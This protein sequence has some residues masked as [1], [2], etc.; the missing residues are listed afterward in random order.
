V[1]PSLGLR[2]LL[3][4]G[5]VTAALP[6]CSEA[7]FPWAGARAT[8]MGGAQVAAVDDATAAWS[9]PAAL[10]RLTGW[11]V[12]LLGSGLASNRNRLLGTVE[13]LS[14]LPFDAIARGDRPDLV[15]GLLDDLNT[16]MRSD[17]SVLFSGVGG[18]VVS[19]RGFALSVGVVPYAG[20]YPVIDLTHVVPGGG[21]DDGLAFNASGLYFR[22]LEAREV[23]LAYGRTLAGVLEVGG[24][25]RIVF[26]RTFFTRCAVFDCG[27][28]N[29]TELVR[30]AFHKNAR[31]STDF[32]FDLGARLNLGILKVGVVG[33]ALNQPTFDVAAVA[34][35]PASVP[36]PRQIRGGVSVDALPFLS[37]AADADLI[38]GDT[39]APGAHSRQVSLGAEARIPVL[40]L[41]AGAMRDLAAT[42]PHWTYSAGVGLSAAVVALDVGV[43]MSPRGGWNPTSHDRE[44]LA[45]AASVRVH[46]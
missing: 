29:L 27:D 40:K 18:L 20:I 33:I 45:G 31:G 37:L 23:R 21:A 34:G 25:A 19:G 35:A 26:G 41:R 17:T 36:L 16:L 32:T 6:S 13:T 1:S 7:Q 10:A 22:G 30:D 43:L 12:E 44:D 39:L 3:L 2:I 14:G 15:P 4:T 11:T 38:E 5:L 28:E 9:N 8:A 42:D 46:F 24:A